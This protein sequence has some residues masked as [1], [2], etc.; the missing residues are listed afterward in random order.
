MRRLRKP[1]KRLLAE[2]TANK[3]RKWATSRHKKQGG[4]CYWCGKTLKES[5]ADHLIPL[6]RGGEDHYEN[7][8]A[9]HSW[10]NS[11]KA[12]RL[13]D[14]FAKPGKYR[15][16]PPKVRKSLQERGHPDATT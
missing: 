13:P 8:V 11:Q 14:E 1:S 12:D 7:I 10:C 2:L 16:M 9:A 3:R 15:P 5:T 4:K 6:S